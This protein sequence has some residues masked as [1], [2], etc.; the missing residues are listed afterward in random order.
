MTETV[1]MVEHFFSLSY[2]RHYLHQYIV[3]L[4]FPLLV[5]INH[6]NITEV[7]IKGERRLKAIL[8]VSLSRII[9][10]ATPFVRQ[11]DGFF[12]DMASEHTK[13][14]LLQPNRT[15][16]EFKQLLSNVILTKFPSREI[17][18]YIAKCEKKLPLFE[19]NWELFVCSVPK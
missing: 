11:M 4:S 1:L 3:M 15:C 12:R 18:L 7:G 10:V 8:S 19:W 14:C 9:L 6:T 17:E 13:S 16:F 2:L 5:I